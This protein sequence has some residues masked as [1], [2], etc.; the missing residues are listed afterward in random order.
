LFNRVKD[1]VQVIKSVIVA[2]FAAISMS[3][4]GKTS[5]EEIGIIF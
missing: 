3:Y 2:A 5:P 4:R 1:L